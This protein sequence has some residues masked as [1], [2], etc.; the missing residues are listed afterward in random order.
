MA[1]PLCMPIKDLNSCPICLGRYTTEG[2]ER[3][4]QVTRGVLSPHFRLG[5]ARS[6]N[7]MVARRSRFIPRVPL[8]ASRIPV[9]GDLFHSLT[10]SRS[11]VSRLFFPVLGGPKQPWVPL[12]KR[13]FIASSA[14]SC[15]SSRPVLG[16]RF[17]T[18][19]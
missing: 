14:L 6:L 19:P 16:T 3:N 8:S 5:L 4:H 9:P 12:C 7:R 10:L 18:Q 17:P 13:W 15:T 11:I 2:F 1:L